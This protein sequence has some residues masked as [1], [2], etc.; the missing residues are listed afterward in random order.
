MLGMNKLQLRYFRHCMTAWL[1]LFFVYSPFSGE[2]P[3]SP[4]Y[5]PLIFL[6]VCG[7]YG[8]WFFKEA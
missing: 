2:I 8:L 7:F 3:I 6:V 1:G 4:T 5:I